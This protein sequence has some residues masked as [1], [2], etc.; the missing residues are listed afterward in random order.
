MKIRD[1]I[2]NNEPQILINNP[3]NGNPYTVKID[4]AEK[5]KKL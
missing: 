5:N 1:N 2:F 3:I 4:L